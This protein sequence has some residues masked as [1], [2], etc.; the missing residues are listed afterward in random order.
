MCQVQREPRGSGV[1][2]PPH[3]GC[4]LD[5]GQISDQVPTWPLKKCWKHF[6][7]LAC[8]NGR[9]RLLDLSHISLNSSP[10]WKG[11]HLHLCTSGALEE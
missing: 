4:A 2:E 6:H 8:D 3:C 5:I 1:P 9:D 11:L 10:P 7:P